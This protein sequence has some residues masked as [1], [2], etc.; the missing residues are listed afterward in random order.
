M[1]WH[2]SFQVE[3][4]LRSWQTGTRD[5]SGTASARYFSSDNYG[6]RTVKETKGTGPSTKTFM[7]IDPRASRFLKSAKDLTEKHWAEIFAAATAFLNN[8]RKRKR[9]Q[10]ASSLASSDF[11][12]DSIPSYSFVSDS[13]WIQF[14]SMPH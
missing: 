3:H 12:E 14:R 10:S 11:V 9:S 6:D 8:S 4:V 1:V 7:K 5:S 13:D 2:V